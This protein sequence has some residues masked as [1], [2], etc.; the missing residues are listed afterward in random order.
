MASEG[1]ESDEVAVGA[2]EWH[3]AAVDLSERVD[4]LARNEGAEADLR[5]SR[6]G[7]EVGAVAPGRVDQP[8]VVSEKSGEVGGAE[9]GEDRIGA[10]GDGVDQTPALIVAEVGIGGRLQARS[11]ACG[12]EAVELRAICR[13]RREPLEL[14]AEI[15]RIAAA[16]IPVV[17]GTD[18]FKSYKRQSTVATASN[19]FLTNGDHVIF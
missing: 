6:S 3:A 15:R 10:V 17:K 5:R 13:R 4:R 12:S 19:A 1:L 18:K 11:D 2:A 14:L 16:G 8:A 7:P 9:I